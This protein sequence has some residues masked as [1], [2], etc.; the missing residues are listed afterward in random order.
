MYWKTSRIRKDGQKSKR[1]GGK[2]QDS[3]VFSTIEPYKTESMAAE[4]VTLPT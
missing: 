1:K 4:E 2:K 3:E